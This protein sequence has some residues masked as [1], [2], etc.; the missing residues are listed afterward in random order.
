M[1][2]ENFLLTKWFSF[3]SD[4]KRVNFKIK[5]VMRDFIASTRKTKR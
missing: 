1:E 3:D 5:D 2:K 4:M